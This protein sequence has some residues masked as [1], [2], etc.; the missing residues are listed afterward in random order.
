MYS[1]A[2]VFCNKEIQI[3][4]VFMCCY[5]KMWCMVCILYGWF[6]TTMEERLS[7]HNLEDFTT[8]KN[9]LRKTLPVCMTTGLL[10]RKWEITRDSNANMLHF[11]R[12]C[13]SQLKDDSARNMKHK[14]NSPAC[15]VRLPE[16]NQ[17]RTGT[18]S[19]FIRM[20]HLPQPWLPSHP[21][22]ISASELLASQIKW[23]QHAWMSGKQGLWELAA[24]R[25]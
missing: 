24:R 18:T 12:V 3:E 15:H 7:E 16:P 6:L 8:W 9:T 19:L 21:P 10:E 1:L 11:W 2:F 4:D 5:I 23:K 17:G 14:Q 20:Q 25:V 22:L 13:C